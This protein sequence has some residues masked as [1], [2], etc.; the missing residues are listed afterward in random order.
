MNPED[1]WNVKMAQYVKRFTTFRTMLTQ[2]TG[3]TDDEAIQEHWELFADNF[4]GCESCADEDEDD[5]IEINVPLDYSADT[6][7]DEDWDDETPTW[8]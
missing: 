1:Y 8:R 4:C 3:I 2:A 7:D 6:A 5:T